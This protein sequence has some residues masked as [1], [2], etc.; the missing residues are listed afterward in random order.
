MNDKSASVTSC[1]GIPADGVDIAGVATRVS[2]STHSDLRFSFPKFSKHAGRYSASE[3]TRPQFTR[4]LRNAD[5]A[6]KGA[7]GALNNDFAEPTV[8]QA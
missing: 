8:S 3:S 7:I 6:G 1:Y 2:P 4:S 5:S